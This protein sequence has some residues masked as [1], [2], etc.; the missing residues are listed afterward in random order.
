MDKVFFETIYETSPNII[1][2]LSDGEI[3][4][5]NKQF[6]NYFGAVSAKEFLNKLFNTNDLDKIFNQNKTKQLQVKVQIE[7]KNYF[8]NIHASYLSNSEAIITMQDISELIDNETHILR[9]SKMDSLSEILHNIAH[10]WRQPLS[11]ISTISTGLL[12]QKDLGVLSDDKLFNGLESINDSTQYLSRVIDEFNKFHLVDK[13]KKEFSL[14]SMF[15]KILELFDVKLSDIEIVLELED[16]VIDGFENELMQVV[17]TMIDNAK[18]ILIDRNIEKKIIK[19]STYKNKDNIQIS[20]HDNANG[21]PDNLKDKV[22]EPY[23]TTKHQKQGVGIGLYMSYELINYYMDGY[24][25]VDNEHFMYK[26][27]EYYGA[28][29]VVSLPVM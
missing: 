5:R 23:F 19:I 14:K 29:F 4:S 15:E 1:F 20:I 6:S 3:I 9:Q 11:V 25:K 8:F 7:N 27:Q 17:L 22:F 26:D 2:V 28:K 10:Q 21:I 12:A 13:E 24:I 18:E 16:Y